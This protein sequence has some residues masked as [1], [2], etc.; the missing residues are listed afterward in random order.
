MIGFSQPGLVSERASQNAPGLVTLFGFMHEYAESSTVCT[1]YS[2]EGDLN[3]DC[4]H[5]QYAFQPCSWGQTR[6][7]IV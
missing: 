7:C 6:C 1:H 5:I 2:F 3:L 4:R